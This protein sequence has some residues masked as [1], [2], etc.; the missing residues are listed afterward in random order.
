MIGHAPGDT[1]PDTTGP[2][3]AARLDAVADGLSGRLAAEEPGLRAEEYERDAGAVLTA[4]KDTRAT[5]MLVP[6]DCGGRGASAADAVR[7]QRALG[8]LAPSAA[9]ASTMHHYKIAALG[10]VAAAGDEHA[11]AILTDLARGA[12]LVASGG[13]ESV[14]GK[15]LR[16]LGS[17]AV[18][19]GDDYLVTGVK[20]PCSLS[21]SMTTMSLMVELRSPEGESE[22]F[23]QAFVPAG[24]PGLEREPFW[25]SPVFLAAESHAVR[26]SGVRVPRGRVFPLRGEPGRRFATDCYTWFQLLVAASYLGVATCLAQATAPERRA[27][28]RGWTEAAARLDR[29][30]AGL[31]DA[32]HA[33]DRGA[34]AAERLNLAV[35]A[36]DAVEDEV[37]AVGGLLLRS[38]GGG[39]FAR[40][41]FFTLL[42]GGL[43]AIAFHPPQRG[44]REGIG[45]EPLDPRSKDK[46]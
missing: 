30:E 43:H 41:G 21:T 18:R 19:D 22:G 27:G 35:R 2:G 11:R 14:P 8:T 15:D 26:L 5:T 7:F 12:E 1:T 32:A 16:S 24:A 39:S 46:H 42:A 34:G 9:I 6:S 44:A 17:R 38:A 31:L 3:L 4:L 28:S 20:R 10:G 40:T 33:V 37:G 23:A 45:L 29:L 36:R 25:R 13:A